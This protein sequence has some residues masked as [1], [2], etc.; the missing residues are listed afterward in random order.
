[1]TTS[2]PQPPAKSS[3]SI[4]P[5]TSPAIRPKQ[6]SPASRT[7]SVRFSYTKSPMSRYPTRRTTSE[8]TH[9]PAAAESSGD[10]ITPIVQRERG[11]SKGKN[12]DSTTQNVVSSS[13]AD[14]VTK[15]RKSSDGKATG[16][17]Q[18]ESYDG[19]RNGLQ[20]WLKEV[21]EKYGSV[22][23]DN[24]GSVARDHLAL[25]SPS[26]YSLFMQPFLS[27]MLSVSLFSPYA[28]R[29]ISTPPPY[30]EADILIQCHRTH[31]PGLASYLPRV[32][33]HWHRRHTAFPFEYHHFRA[34]GLHT[35]RSR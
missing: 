22:E 29:L 4:S 17:E 21:A 20:G 8:A 28:T 18:E 24:K 5:N 3:P 2:P 12:Y 1:M 26:S 6:S 32:R 15:Q 33:F 27:L 31:F 19:G 35:R 23:L 7:H 30:L 9:Q 10:E 14:T 11:S 16:N 13:S 34:R 25:G